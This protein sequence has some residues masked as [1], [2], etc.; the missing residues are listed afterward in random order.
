MQEERFD[1]GLRI[2]RHVDRHGV[3]REV[4][5]GRVYVA[6]LRW[7]DDLP[8]GIARRDLARFGD[9]AREVGPRAVRGSR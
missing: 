8:L 6:D 9:V 2:G 5:R 1:R 7:S 3:Q 4:A